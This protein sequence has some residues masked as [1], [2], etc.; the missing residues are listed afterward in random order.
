MM[1]FLWQSE[2][3]IFPKESSLAN[4]IMDYLPGKKLLE[5]KI[6]GMSQ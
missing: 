6:M 5:V 1:S 4:Y 2:I 3:I